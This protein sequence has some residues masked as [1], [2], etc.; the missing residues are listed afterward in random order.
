MSVSAARKAALIISNLKL[1]SQRSAAA[2]AA[3]R[4][5]CVCVY[6]IPADMSGLLSMLRAIHKKFNG[7]IGRRFS[8]EM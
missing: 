3:L 6:R 7:P 8:L 5:V 2:A 1:D 4:S